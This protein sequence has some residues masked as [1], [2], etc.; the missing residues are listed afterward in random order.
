MRIHS[1]AADITGTYPYTRW[2]CPRENKFGILPRRWKGADSVGI[3]TFRDLIS[4]KLQISPEWKCT[5]CNFPTPCKRNLKYICFWYLSLWRLYPKP[6]SKQ[7]ESKEGKK[8]TLSFLFLHVQSNCF[9]QQFS[10]SCRWALSTPA[11]TAQLQTSLS[12]E[13]GKVCSHCSTGTKI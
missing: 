1:W 3:N 10:Q 6:I 5:E 12:S 11:G 2:N 9:Y 13:G 8:P 4:G 7:W